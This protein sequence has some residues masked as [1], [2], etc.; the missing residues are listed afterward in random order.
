VLAEWIH[1]H[2]GR[3]GVSFS[4]PACDLIV[5]LAGPRTRDIVQLAR[6]VWDAASRTDQADESLVERAMETLVQEQGA[7]FSAQW[8]GSQT[9]DQRVLRAIAAEPDLAVQST[10]ALQRY[11]LGPKSTVSSSLARLVENEIL[12]RDDGGQYRFDDPFFRRWIQRFALADLGLATP[13]LRIGAHRSKAG[14]PGATT[15]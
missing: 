2:A 11:R 8:R 10:D 7:L 12:S 13:P 9:T 4:L 6:V 3:T 15:T 5:E 14:Q 1:Q